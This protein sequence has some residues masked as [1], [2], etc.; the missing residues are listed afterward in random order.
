MS[1]HEPCEAALRDCF[2]LKSP[3]P[4]VVR[5]FRESRF[6]IADG[7]PDELERSG[8]GRVTSESGFILSLQRKDSTAHELRLGGR[9]VHVVPF[10]Q[11]MMSLLTLAL[12]PNPYSDDTFA[13]CS[14]YFRRATFDQLADDLGEIRIDEFDFRPG[15]AVND[16]VVNNLVPC[17]RSSMEQPE[18]INTGF[19]DHVVNAL[20]THL[21]QRYGGLRISRMTE[22]G[23]LAPWQLRLARDTINAHLE[24]PISLAQIAGDCGLSV[25][26]FAKAFKC[27][28]GVSPH[29]WLTQR[30]I[31]R[32]KELM[33][34]TTTLLAQIALVCGFSDQSH[35]NRVFSRATGTTPNQWRRAN[36]K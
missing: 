32:A 30:R 10:P 14:L 18:R 9:R 33:R 31:H 24:G 15:I 7:R 3:A 16:P 35:F 17:L 34:T 27:S 1:V 6:T 19:I 13:C 20:H 25:S 21:A 11:G 12:D 28:T 36:T 26:H 8:G 2:H 4:A 22:R 23:S 5:A 29:R